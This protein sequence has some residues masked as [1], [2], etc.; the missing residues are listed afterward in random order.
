M[1]EFFQLI[2]ASYFNPVDIGGMNRSNLESILELLANDA[3]VDII[4]MLRGVQAARRRDDDELRSELQAYKDAS[5]KSGKPLLAML[6]TPTP[7]TDSSQIAEVDSI[8]MEFGIP[9]FP[10]PGRA[11]RAVKKMVDYYRFRQSVQN[12]ECGSRSHFGFR[13][14]GL[15]RKTL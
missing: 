15:C 10:T 9:A 14:G 2:G 11:A 6:W 3:N 8:L 13:R 7:Y 4:A 1:G 5:D 12:G